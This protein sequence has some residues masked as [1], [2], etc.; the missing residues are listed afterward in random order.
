MENWKSIPKVEL[1][2]H[3]EGSV[4]LST[5]L[6]L[7]PPELKLKTVDDAR[8]Y[9]C[10]TEPMKDLTQCLDKFGY[11]QKLFNSVER[12][13]RI[14]YEVVEDC[15]VDGIKVLELRYSPT[16][17][18]LGHDHLTP[19]IIHDAVLKGVKRATDQ[20]EICV[21][22]IGII[23]RFMPVDQAAEA[24]Q[25]LIDNK[26]TFLAI[27]LAN[28]EAKFDCLAFADLFQMAKT[29]GLRV[30]VHSGEVNVPEAPWW[31]K[32]AIDHLLADRIGHGIHVLKDS[33]VV[34]HAKNKGV[35]FEVS[36]SSNYLC[37]SVPS[38]HEHVVKEMVAQGLSV[39]LNTDDPGLFDVSLSGE[40]EKA[41]SLLGFSVEQICRMM[42]AAFEASF[43]PEEIRS[44]FY[45]PRPTSS[46]E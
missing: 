9:Y 26:D 25:F 33:S 39:G 2:R 31:V 15:F 4:R 46:A 17:I 32:N 27:D 12:I 42:D 30:T 10:I 43:I 13:E 37:N 29:A 34:E 23:D 11:T 41:H 35:H 16:Y 44:K 24:T 40:L 6:D 14:T 21:G 8:A 18:N 38:V 3:L 5:Y 1:H 20:F 45:C 22:L 19:Q 7:S 36:M 28:D